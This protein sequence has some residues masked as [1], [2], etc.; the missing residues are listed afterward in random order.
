MKNIF[1][2]PSR[3][4][5]LLAAGSPKLNAKLKVSIRR[6]SVIALHGCRLHFICGQA[7][8]DTLQLN[9]IEFLSL[10]ADP[11]TAT[12]NTSSSG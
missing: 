11:R 9:K 2:G 3:P 6:Q 4:L 12:L 7:A 8:T 5:L 1:P 10:L